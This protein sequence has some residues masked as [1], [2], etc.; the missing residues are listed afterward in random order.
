MKSKTATRASVRL[1]NVLRSIG[2]R[3][4]SCQQILEPDLWKRRMFLVEIPETRYAK[5][6]GVKKLDRDG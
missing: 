6:V 3:C 4:P 1:R 5:T 2:D